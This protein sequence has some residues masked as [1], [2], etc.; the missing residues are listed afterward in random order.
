MSKFRVLSD[1]IIHVKT[2][3]SNSITKCIE[4]KKNNKREMCA[5]KTH[6][7]H[8]NHS[9]FLVYSAQHFAWIDA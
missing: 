9:I 5:L 1:Y 4:I 8:T 7:N 2:M 6:A 3:T